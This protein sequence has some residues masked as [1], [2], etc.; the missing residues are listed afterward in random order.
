MKR[1]RD[2]K[3]RQDIKNFKVKL[4]IRKDHGA[5]KIIKETGKSGN[6]QK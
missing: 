4:G 2:K 1:K 3:G 5:A 6:K